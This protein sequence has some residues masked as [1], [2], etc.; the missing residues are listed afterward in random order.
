[1]AETDT[2]TR[3]LLSFGCSCIWSL[4]FCKSHDPVTDIRPE[5][6]AGVLEIST[7]LKVH[8]SVCLREQNPMICF[9]NAFFVDLWLSDSSCSSEYVPFSLTVTQYSQTLSYLFCL[10]TAITIGAIPKAWCGWQRAV[11]YSKTPWLQ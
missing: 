2:K 1:M 7:I 5:K 8:R 9:L 10:A 3:L 6:L 11:G 4:T